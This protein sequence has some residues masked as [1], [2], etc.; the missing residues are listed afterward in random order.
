MGDSGIVH[1]DLYRAQGADLVKDLLYLPLISD[2]ALV[3]L[4][5][6]ALLENRGSCLPRMRLVDLKDVY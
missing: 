2:V 1:E 5:G 3:P 4:R 6:A